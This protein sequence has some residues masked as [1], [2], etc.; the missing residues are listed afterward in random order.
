LSAWAP[1]ATSVARRS[2]VRER[3]PSPITC[4]HLAIAAS[5]LERLLYPDRF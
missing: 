4:F 5:A 3:S 2:S 1:T